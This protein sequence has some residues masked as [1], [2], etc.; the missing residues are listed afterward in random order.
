MQVPEG[1]QEQHG[2]AQDPGGAAGGWHQAQGQHQGM[3]S[4][5]RAASPSTA[6]QTANRLISCGGADPTVV[7]V[8]HA[9]PQKAECTLSGC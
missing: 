8:M 7:V 9:T 6:Q 4:G 5:S 2:P 1:V 3:T